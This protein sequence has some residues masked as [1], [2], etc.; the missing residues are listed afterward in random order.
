M[1][2]AGPSYNLMDP[3][4]VP[5]PDPARRY[6]W[7]ATDPRRLSLWLR[8]YGEVPG[9]SL[10]QGASI[11]DTKALAERLGLSD[12][13]VDA[14]NRIVYGHNVLADI[15]VEEYERRVSERVDEQLDKLASAKDEFHAKAEGLHG[16]KTF[17][18]TPEETA[19]RK[20]FHQREPGDRPFV[21]QAGQGTSPLLRP[22]RA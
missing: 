19:D 8:S 6:R 15:P 17:E 1:P 11:K 22:R 4:G 9:Y 10:V 2:Y 14:S 7:I 12:R 5:N 13:L 20:E 21:G 18:Q 16:I 3:W